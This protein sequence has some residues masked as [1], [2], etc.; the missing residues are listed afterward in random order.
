MVKVT[1]SFLSPQNMLKA[2]LEVGQ[3]TCIYCKTRLVV[4]L[5]LLFFLLLYSFSIE[6]FPFCSVFAYPSFLGRRQK[7]NIGKTTFNWNSDYVGS[8]CH[9]LCDFGELLLCFNVLEM[10]VWHIRWYFRSL[11]LETQIYFPCIQVW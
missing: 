7:R 8:R 11:E 3:S 6:L 1:F 9:E 4:V 10:R 5:T 2:R